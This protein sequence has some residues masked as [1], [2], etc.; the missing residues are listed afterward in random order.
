MSKSET[1]KIV[2]VGPRDGLQNEASV[3][4][5]EQ[6]FSLIERLYK[7]G[8]RNIEVG[9]L[10]NPTRMPQMANSD[11]LYKTLENSYFYSDVHAVP[12]LV[13]NVRGM[14]KAIELGVKEIACFTAASDTFNE[15]NIGCDIEDSFARIGDVMA[16]AQQ[17]GIAVRG[18]LSCIVSCPYEGA[19]AKSKVDHLTQRL[20]DMGCYEVSLGDTIGVATPGQITP[21]IEQILKHTDASKLALH[22]H[23]TYGQALA[24]ICAGLN[25]GIRTFD[26][27]IAGL[28]GCPYAPGASGNVATEDLVYMLHGMGYKTQVD[29]SLLVETGFFISKILGRSNSAKVGQALLN[30]KGSSAS[31]E[32]SCI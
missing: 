21:L 31:G 10:V 30:K 19:I 5:V 7:S 4:T 11:E 15:K 29:L 1:V 17:H 20:L 16:L 24:N 9:S 25:L 18:Y 28:G 22:L 2:E 27:S 3:L 12:M 8:L 13:P 6:K 23:D 32:N 14:E 26:S